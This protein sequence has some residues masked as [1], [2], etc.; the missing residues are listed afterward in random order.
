MNK[1]IFWAVFLF[2]GIFLIKPA[3]AALAVP[4]ECELRRQ[5]SVYYCAPKIPDPC[6]EG[7]NCDCETNNPL[8][9]VQQN[10]SCNYGTCVEDRA[11]GDCNAGETRSWVVSEAQCTDNEDC[12]LSGRIRAHTSSLECCCVTE[13]QGPPDQELFFQPDQCL[14][15]QPTNPEDEQDYAGIETAIGCIPTTPQVFISWFLNKAIAIGG[16]IAFLLMV[17]GAFQI[18]TSSGDPE[19]L[20]EGKEIII[21]AGAGLLFIIFSVFIL[22]LIGVDI[23]KIPGWG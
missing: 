22:E 23:L 19:K 10:R 2:L 14:V 6:G 20:Q 12:Y 9:E 7:W 5:D 8:D 13:P 17:W 1:K 15:K 3:Q 11:R 16:G 4:C 18:M 21:S